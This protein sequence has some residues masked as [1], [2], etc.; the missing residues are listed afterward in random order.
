MAHP[1]NYHAEYQRRLDLGRSRG[2]TQQESRGHGRTPERPLQALGDPARWGNYIRQNF[3][4]ID[5]LQNTPAG[6]RALARVN[7]R[8]RKE[9]KAPIVIGPPP[10]PG[11]GVRQFTSDSFAE[12]ENRSAGPPPDYVTLYIWRGGFTVEKRSGVHRRRRA[13]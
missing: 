5:A 10:D 8:R 1:R 7:D 9:G 6:V 13:A 4:R 11:A 3:D 12:A 2:L